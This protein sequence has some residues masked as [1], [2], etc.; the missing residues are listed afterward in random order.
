MQPGDEA[1]LT[2]P[3]IVD[4]PYHTFSPDWLSWIRLIQ[5]TKVVLVEP[6][7]WNIH[8]IVW[9]GWQVIADFIGDCEPWLPTAWLST[10]NSTN[11]TGFCNSCG[12]FRRHKL[13][14]PL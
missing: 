14:C 9:P 6:D 2:V 8:F 11:F 5:G 12:G 7:D 10:A 1:I 4:F 3:V 13:G